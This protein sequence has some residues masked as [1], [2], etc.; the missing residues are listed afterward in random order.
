MLKPHEYA[1]LCVASDVTL[2]F[3]D[4]GALR[5][6]LITKHVVTIFHKLSGIVST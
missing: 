5:N 4:E 1:L 3:T 6:K 2:H